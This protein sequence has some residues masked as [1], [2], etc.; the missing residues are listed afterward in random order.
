MQAAAAASKHHSHHSATGRAQPPSAAAATA[1]GPSVAAD[2]AGRAALANAS[3]RGAAGGASYSALYQRQPMQP[4][5]G[6]LQVRL[7]GPLSSLCAQQPSPTTCSVQLAVRML[8]LC[9]LTLTRLCAERNQF[10]V[11]AW[12]VCRAVHPSPH[13]KSAADLMRDLA[14]AITCM[15]TCQERQSMQ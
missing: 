10:Y 7:S 11:T 1:A 3:Q 4:D 6:A 14:S 15:H 8:G 5:P 12:S 2:P 13:R 9:V